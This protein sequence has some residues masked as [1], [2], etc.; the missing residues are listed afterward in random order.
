MLYDILL[1]AFI[2]VFALI[3]KKRGLIGSVLSFASVILAYI[4]SSVFT[5]AVQKVF[6]KTDIYA[7]IA[8]KIGE[9]FA[10]NPEINIP[11]LSGFAVGEGINVAENMTQLIMRAA[12][13]VIVFFAAL[14][15]LKILA[16]VLSA[17][18]KLPGLNFINATG[19]LV[20][21][22]LEGF[23]ITYVILAVWGLFTM[24]ETPSVMEGTTLL[25]SMFENNLLFIF[26]A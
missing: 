9:H 1:V 25:K 18:F 4:I 19:G 8:E 14:I 22:L 24:L 10:K 2:A 7:D 23:I 13:S 5:P 16:K 17:I 11:F 3:G 15:I 12:T 6:V 20:L 26:F 21:G